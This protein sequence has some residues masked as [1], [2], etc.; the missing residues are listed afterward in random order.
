MTSVANGA[1]HEYVTNKLN[2]FN[3]V[4][5][6]CDLEI[7]NGKSNGNGSNEHLNGDIDVVED[8]NI[9]NNDDVNYAIRS[10]S[11]PADEDDDDDEIEEDLSDAHRLISETYYP[12]GVCNGERDLGENGEHDHLTSDFE[13]V[14]EDSNICG[15]F[16]KEIY[17]KIRE[18]G[19]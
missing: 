12:N 17:L 18:L 5:I 1:S 6:N 7:I 14:D 13:E 2:S 3:K 8:E 19:L 10:H 4:Y 11:A 16:G 15:D 9:I